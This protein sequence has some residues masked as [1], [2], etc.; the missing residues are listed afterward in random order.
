MKY[1]LTPN[2]MRAVDAAATSEFGIPSFTLM[3]HAA[4]SAADIIRRSIAQDCPNFRGIIHIVCG[5]GNNGGDGLALARLLHEEYT[6][7]VILLREG[8]TLT[9]DAA[10]N[11]TILKALGLR[12]AILDS[13]DAA[14]LPVIT[15]EDVVVDALIGIG[16][17]N[18]LRGAVRELLQ[19]I[20]R[21][22]VQFRVAIDVPTGL[23]SFTGA[24]DEDCFRANLTI[25]MAAEK[26]GLLLRDGL[27]SCGNIEPAFIGA[28][29]NL[30]QKYASAA[31]LEAADAAKFLSDRPIISS[32]FDYGRVVIIAGSRQMPG[33]A[34]LAANAAI[35]AGAGLV[36]LFTPE[37]HPA[38][39]PEILLPETHSSK[40]GY[41]SPDDL[42]A[43]AE[44]I[45]KADSV[46][47][48]PGLGMQPDTAEFIRKIAPLFHGKP[49]IFDADALAVTG[50][51]T[52]NNQSILTPHIG[53]FSRM[54]GLSREE[55]ASNPLATARKFASETG[56]ILHLKH[57]PS[58]TTDG[59]VTYFTTNGNPGMATAGSGDVLAGIVGALAARGKPP[60]TAAAL[61][62]Y[63]HAAAGDIYAKRNGME[64]L[65]ASRLIAMLR[66]VL[67]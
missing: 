13:F 43:V 36:Q 35:T 24:A 19:C 49:V 29:Q 3:E 14:L 44:G 56:A 50:G 55:I 31:R 16:G 65:T 33:A 1:I 66:E 26:T 57:V 67:P 53:E 5:A 45:E 38:M 9:V 17:G 8:K 2:E 10:A 47:V 32:K 15:P 37:R 7:S 12:C 48:G 40:T 59:D 23:D 54:T 63:I 46:V 27:N 30:I 41:F 28:P 61:G 51:I 34:A 4:R 11:L 21:L 39:L 22:P 64:T 18:N 42:D 60:L 62:A 20:N 58:L 25:T 6:V 52:L